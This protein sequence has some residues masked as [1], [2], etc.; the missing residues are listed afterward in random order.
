ME[1]RIREGSERSGMLIDKGVIVFN[2]I[3]S[4]TADNIMEGSERSGMLIDEGVRS[5]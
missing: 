1:D 3:C 4:T 2:G 5:V